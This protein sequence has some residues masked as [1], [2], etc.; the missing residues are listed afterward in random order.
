MIDDDHP[1]MQGVPDPLV[2]DYVSHSVFDNV[3][4]GANVIMTGSVDPRP[5][6]IEYPLGAGQVLATTQYLEWAVDNGRATG[7][8]LE[9]TVPYVH[10]FVPVIG[11]PW[12]SVSP[13]SGPSIHASLS[14]SR[15]SAS[16]EVM[17]G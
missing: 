16:G 1:T 11:V 3:P 15:S 9:N 13:D 10:D 12:M 2:D 7:L 6:V 4:E 17:S 5:T 14:E 8:I